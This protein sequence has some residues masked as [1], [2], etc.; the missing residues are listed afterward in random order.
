M[1]GM[2]L[3]SVYFTLRKLS[4]R[5]NDLLVF[6]FLALGLLWLLITNKRMSCPRG[7]NVAQ[8]QS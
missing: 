2:T 8:D 1:S 5:K 4:H 3:V 6:T 7:L